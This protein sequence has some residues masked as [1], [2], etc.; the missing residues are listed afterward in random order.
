MFLI[1]MSTH[2]N[3]NN[4]KMYYFKRSNHDNINSEKNFLILFAILLI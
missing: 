2:I 3:N 4:N 1:E